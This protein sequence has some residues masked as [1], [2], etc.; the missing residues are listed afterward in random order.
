MFYDRLES[1][2]FL[3]KNCYKHVLEYEEKARQ[4]LIDALPGY[5]W[6]K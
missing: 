5:E 6:T 1:G 2:D 3:I 4:R